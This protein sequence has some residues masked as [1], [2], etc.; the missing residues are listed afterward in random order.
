MRLFEQDEILKQSHHCINLT[1][2]NL[3]TTDLSLSGGGNAK[4][5]YLILKIAMGNLIYFFFL[6]K[7]IF[8]ES[9]GLHH[10]VILPSALVSDHTVQCLGQGVRLATDL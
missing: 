2:L 9:S 8:L 3:L 4:Y 6:S 5:L 1:E 10:H 7:K